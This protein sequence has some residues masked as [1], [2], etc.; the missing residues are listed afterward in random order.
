MCQ[1]FRVRLARLYPTPGQVRALARP[2]GCARVVFN[3][4]LA[5]ERRRTGWAAVRH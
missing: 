3:D 1:K 5:P 2:F 4:A